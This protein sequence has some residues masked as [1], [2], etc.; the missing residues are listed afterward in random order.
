[1]ELAQSTHL[2]TEA[3]PFDYDAAKADRLRAHLRVIL[4][5]LATAAPSLRG[6]P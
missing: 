1:M 3:L 2:A 4:E 6:Q 5:A